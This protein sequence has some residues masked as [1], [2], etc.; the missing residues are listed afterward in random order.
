[1]LQNF[2]D[3]L[4]PLPSTL[5]D[6]VGKETQHP[7]RFQAP[8]NEKMRLNRPPGLTIAPNGGIS[9]AEANMVET[10]PGVLQVR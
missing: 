1:M 9:D 8:F 2:F 6:I 5:R 4:K 7:Y 10:T 3:E